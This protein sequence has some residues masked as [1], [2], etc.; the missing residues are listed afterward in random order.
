MD[1]SIEKYISAL[2]REIRIL[3]EVLRQTV[4]EDTT[5]TID[6]TLI[7]LQAV[8]VV[9]KSVYSVMKHRLRSN[10]SRCIYHQLLTYL[11]I[12]GIFLPKE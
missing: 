12:F 4:V 2:E 6:L 8:D 1:E 11:F 7:M 5:R 10:H 9:Q 3:L